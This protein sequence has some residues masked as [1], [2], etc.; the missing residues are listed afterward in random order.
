MR[1]DHQAEIIYLIMAQSFRLRLVGG[2][3]LSFPPAPVVVGSALDDLGAELDDGWRG[4]ED[5]LFDG[6]II[7][8]PLLFRI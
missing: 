7:P 4:V 8:P 6:I 2:P 1:Y 3:F 5:E